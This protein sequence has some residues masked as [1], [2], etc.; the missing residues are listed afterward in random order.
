MAKKTL[1]QYRI[2]AGL[3]TDEFAKT[4]GIAES[5]LRS[6]ENGNRPIKPEVARLIEEVTRGQVRREELRPDVFGAIA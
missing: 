5:T 4:L 6:Y 1:R 2:R 3:S